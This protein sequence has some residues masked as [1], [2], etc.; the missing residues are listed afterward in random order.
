MFLE[1]V[2]VNIGYTDNMYKILSKK[3]IIKRTPTKSK[4]VICD[5]IH[6]DRM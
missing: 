3:Y 6:S 1:N 5:V 2:Q 4:L